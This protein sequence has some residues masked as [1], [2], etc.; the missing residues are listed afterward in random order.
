MKQW[1]LLLSFIVIAMP[2]FAQ[3]IDLRSMAEIRQH[4]I[5]KAIPD[6]QRQRMAAC[7]DN[8]TTPS[9][10][11]APWK[12]A[13]ATAAG[14]LPETSLAFVRIAD[15]FNADDLSANGFDVRSVFGD[16]ALVNIAISDVERMSALECVKHLQLQRQLHTNMD[17]ARA[18]QGVDLIHQ[19]SE[20]AGLSV[21]YTG[22]GVITGIIDQGIDPHHI[23]FRYADGSSRI[24][25]LWYQFMGKEGP[26]YKFYNPLT[27]KD[28]TT[29][30]Q[31]AYHATHTLGIMSGSYNGPVTVA[32]PW[33]DPTVPETPTLITENCKYYGVAPEATIAISCGELQDGFIAFGVQDIQNYAEWLRENDPDRPW[34][35]VWNLSLGSNQGPHDKRTSL[36]QVLDIFGQKGIVCVSAGNEG[37]LKIALK[38][39]FTEEERTVKTLIY[40]FGFQYDPSDPESFTARNGS[41]EIYSDDAT[42]FKLKAVI[43][44]KSRG[45]RAVKN[46]GVVGENIG[47]YYCSSDAY[48]VTDSDIVGDNI[49]CRAYEGYVGVG[50]KIHEETGRYYGMV[51][52]YVINNIASN[53]DDNYVLGFEVEG[54]PGHSIE[55]YGDAQNTWMDNYGVEGFT[56]GSTDGTIS[57]MAMADNI[58]VVGS[59][60]TRNRW[61]C[62]DGGT[63]RY[64]GA[65]FTVGGISG[66][67]SYGSTSD[68]RDLPTVCAPGS[69]IIS[70]VSY[71]FVKAIEENEN[72]GPDYLKLMCQAK[73]EESDRVNYW[74]QEVGT[75]MSTPFVSGSIALWLEANPY[76][77]VNAI[78]EIIRKSSV[79]DEQVTSTREQKR[80]GAGKFNALAG[81]KEA[82]RMS[83]LTGIKADGHNDRLTLTSDGHRLYTAFVGDATEMDVKVYASD[84]RLVLQRTGNGDEL[85]FDLSGVPT[86]IY[87]VN[88]NGHHTAKIAVK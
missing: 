67:S 48:K 43:Y 42:P 73:L 71:P 28:F 8:A 49:F 46:M 15:G 81:L 4:K 5:M 21:P 59:Y 38:K 41:I 40:P 84:G 80:W 65:G 68:G 78:K 87:I 31:G 57:D 13:R 6:N 52:Y 2:S 75:S 33:A 3:K 72:Y 76:L 29:D 61:V 55:C 70:S 47:T 9:Q 62:L 19:G 37:D 85:S 74:K 63:S 50:G 35:L 23:N 32:K 30:A 58:I 79:R 14:T 53:L 88:A 18:E 7:R 82:I 77:D 86:G 27:I 20:E 24:E 83:G 25:G 69:A 54:E 34:P 39:T 16:I 17:V 45:Y 12:A 56:D 60:N 1:R 64:E 66:F 44:S 51:D 36:N 22:K 26:D 10:Q 11:S